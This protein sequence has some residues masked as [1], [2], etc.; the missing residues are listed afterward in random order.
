[1]SKKLLLWL[2]IGDILLLDYTALDDITTGNEPNFMEEYAILI[3]SAL[4]FTYLVLK[5]FTGKNI[6][7]R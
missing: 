7:F 3:L 2:I 5:R 4:F 6:Q 1:M